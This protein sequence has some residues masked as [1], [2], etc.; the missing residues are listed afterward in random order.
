VTDWL[1]HSDRI[2]EVKGK[3]GWEKP[4]VAKSDAP[5]RQG[6]WAVRALVEFVK[7]KDV[8]ACAGFGV[9]VFEFGMGG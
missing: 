9:W 2:K 5:S 4:D 7:G 8:K 1:P 6:G 3:R